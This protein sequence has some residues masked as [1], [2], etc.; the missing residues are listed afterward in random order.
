MVLCPHFPWQEMTEASV[1]L[2]TVFLFSIP[3]TPC[4]LYAL[5]LF[6]K[7]LNST[8]CVPRTIG[9]VNIN[10]YKQLNNP[11][12]GLLLFYHFTDEK[13]EVVKKLVEGHAGNGAVGI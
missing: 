8:Y 11:V 7:H 3:L 2:V 5:P 4:I 6:N 9:F 10:S 12:K 1:W 13:T